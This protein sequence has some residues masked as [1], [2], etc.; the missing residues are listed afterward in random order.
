[1]A[2]LDSILQRHSVWRG[3]AF[4]KSERVAHG[5]LNARHVVLTP[6]GARIIDFSDA[7]FSAFVPR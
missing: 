1:M 5:R 7:S 2:V 4:L 6:E 3:A